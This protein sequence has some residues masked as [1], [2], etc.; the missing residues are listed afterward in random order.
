MPANKP[1]D[2]F[3]KY[4]SPSPWNTQED[5]WD[6]FRNI[7][8][9]ITLV[10]GIGLLVLWQFGDGELL[11]GFNELM[12]TGALWIILGTAAPILIVFFLFLGIKKTVE[13]KRL[14]IEDIKHQYHKNKTTDPLESDPWQTVLG[15][16]QALSKGKQ[17]TMPNTMKRIGWIIFVILFILPF[18]FNL[19]GQLFYQNQWDQLAE[20]I[21][22]YNLEDYQNLQEQFPEWEDIEIITP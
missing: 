4:Q 7:L 8:L 16:L 20:E 14:Q 1:Q 2:D 17:A 5:K 9:I 12:N 3:E 6:K 18:I 19:I 22:D 15:T 10:I 11:E 13:Q 21:E